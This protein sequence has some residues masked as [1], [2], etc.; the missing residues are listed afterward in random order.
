MI[1]ES[2]IFDQLS[3]ETRSQRPEARSK[4]AISAFGCLI[5]ATSVY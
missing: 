5:K 4:T 3:Q 1:A 2:K